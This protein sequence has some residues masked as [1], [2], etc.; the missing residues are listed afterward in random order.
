MLDQL[1]VGVVDLESS[2]RLLILQCSSAPTSL[3]SCT[4]LYSQGALCGLVLA[5]HQHSLPTH[6]CA[7]LQ[8]ELLDGRDKDW[9]VNGKF[10]MMQ[11]RP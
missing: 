4:W 2:H 11:F 9:Q 10:A 5:L 7:W 1:G 8:A 3:L 6:V